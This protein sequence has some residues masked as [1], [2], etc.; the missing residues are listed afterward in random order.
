MTGRPADAERWLALA[1]GATS[2]IPLSDGTAT[3][4]PWVANLR[5]GM[6]PHGVEQAIADADLAL[7]RLS[8]ESGWRPSAL[9]VRG[10]AHAIVG[11]T[12]RATDDLVAAIEAG[13]AFGFSDVV[14]LGYA[15]LALLAAKRGEWREAGRLGR[16][17]QA[18]V[19]KWGL[20]DY[21]T[22]ALV[23]ATTARIALHE[24]R[25]ED[26]RTALMR[27]HRLRP[28]LDHGVPWLSI[29]VGLE[30]TRAHLTLADAGA[31][32]TVFAETE[33]VLELR[34]HMGTLAD[35]ARE[36]R[37]RVEATGGSTGAWAMSLTAAE[38]RLLPFLATHLTFPEIA[39]R[40]F[41]SRNTVKSEAVAVYRK[42]GVA[43]RSDAMERAVEVGLLESSIFPPSPGLALGG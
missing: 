23:H 26:A 5:A 6:M 15:Q 19:D 17:A 28:L 35:D 38:L 37:P 41:I 12:E 36:L 9:V 20:G 43:S 27:A 39:S 13:L 10:T 11:A 8:P 2:R 14:Y 24:S 31:A 25:T 33:R 1:D 42:L 16:E 4:E 3:I 34:P 32:R 30:L 40:L 18:G 7:D 22:S 21:S 29:A